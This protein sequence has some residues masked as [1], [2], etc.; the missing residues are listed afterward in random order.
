[1][2]RKTGSSGTFTTQDKRALLKNV[3]RVRTTAITLGLDPQ[4]LDASMQ[5]KQCK[6]LTLHPSWLTSAN[7]QLDAPPD[8]ASSQLWKASST[9]SPTGLKSRACRHSHKVSG[10]SL[11]QHLPLA[12]RCSSSRGQRQR[13]EAEGRG[14]RAEGRW[15]RAAAAAEGSHDYTARGQNAGSAVQCSYRL[16]H[17]SAT[18]DKLIE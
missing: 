1:M 16:E 18:L 13:A 7:R 17:N 14:Q 11:A 9:C 2:R 4:V 8:P 5:C 6:W 12:K 15:Q 3:D 10:S